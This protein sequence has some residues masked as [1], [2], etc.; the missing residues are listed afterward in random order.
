MRQARG[1][2]LE[3]GPAAVWFRLTVPIVEGE[4]P[5]PLQR[6]AAAA[7]FGNGISGTLER[8][9]HLFINPDLSVYVHREAQGEWIGLDAA[10][11]VE[12]YGIGLAVGVLRDETGRIGTSLQ[13]L[14]IDKLRP[15]R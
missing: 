2:W 13:S 1:S 12:P 9:A 6:V 5:S 8:G 10:T 15:P 14:I 7:D 11:A 4:E 3:E